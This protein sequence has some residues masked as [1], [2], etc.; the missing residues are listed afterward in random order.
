MILRTRGQKRRRMMI[1][2]FRDSLLWDVV[3]KNDDI[4]FKHILPRLNRTDVKF[5]YEVN[6]ETR[7]LIKRSSRAGDL[8]KGFRVSEMSSISTLEI[9]WENKSLWTRWWSADELFCPQVARTNKLELLKWA[10]EDLLINF[11]VSVFTS[12]KNLT[13]VPFNLGRMCLK[14]ISSLFTIKLHTSLS[15]IRLLCALVLT[16]EDMTFVSRHQLL[17]A[18]FFFLSS[19]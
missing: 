5:L 6:T 19:S 11:L 15:P 4:C 13:S 9:A 3:V 2:E 1:W 18:L 12:Y 10:R 8:K 16:P 7:K 14:Q 17:L